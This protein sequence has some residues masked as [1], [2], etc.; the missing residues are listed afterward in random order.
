MKYISDNLIAL[1]QSNSIQWVAVGHTKM[2]TY[3]KEH[4]QINGMLFQA[5]K[6]GKF[7]T[8]K[9]VQFF[10]GKKGITNPSHPQNPIIISHLHT[11]KFNRPENTIH[12]HF[13]FGNIPSPVTDQDM[14]DVFSDLWISKAKQSGKKIWLQKA[15]EDNT[16]WIHY[17]HNEIR[18]HGRLGLDINSTYIPIKA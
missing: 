1:P 9:L 11:S 12:Y 10:N 16:D 13:A 15:S 8:R 18:I 17:G 2:H 7:F 3:N 14:M 5:Q 4:W 6:T